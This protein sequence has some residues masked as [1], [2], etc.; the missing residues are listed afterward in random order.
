[1]DPL[2]H[3]DGLFARLRATRRAEWESYVA[4]PFV[5]GLGRG[6]LPADS[7]R[8]YLLQD[9]LFLVHYAR[10]WAL[11]CCKAGTLED[12]RFAQACVHAILDVEMELHVTYCAQWGIA[13]AEIEA[14]DEAN[15]TLAY[16]RFV[17][18]AG[19]QGDVLDLAVA[20]A[21]CALGYAEIAERLLADPA[22]RRD[23][24]PYAPWIDMYASPEFRDVARGTADFVDRLW[25]ARANR[26]RLDELATRFGRACRLEAAFWQMGLERAP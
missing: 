9:Y 23:G 18:D 19:L 4:H 12:M 8:H 13:R 22:T 16:T 11:A 17:I 14:V 7:F 10:A 20:L 3:P 15:A 25:D 24:N 2:F 5:T 1:M 6:T 21:P 26:G